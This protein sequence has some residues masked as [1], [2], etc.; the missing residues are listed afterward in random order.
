MSQSILTKHQVKTFKGT[1]PF[2][3]KDS[4]VKKGETEIVVKA[5][6]DDH[7][8]NGH[9]TLA[10]T[11]TTYNSW[12]CLHE[13]ILQAEGI[14]MEIKNLIPFHLCGSVEPLY[15]I[16][17]TLYWIGKKNL[18]NARISAIADWNKEHILWM[19]D[20]DLGNEEKLRSRLPLVMEE[21]EKLVVGAGFIW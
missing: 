10:I 19:S 16:Q 1:F 13:E 15:Y 7:C 2:F 4:G 9:N 11:G 21:M 17:N 8:N 5:R 3:W 14:P 6:W 18:Q 20:E 12:R